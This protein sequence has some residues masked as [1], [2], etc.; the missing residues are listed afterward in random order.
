[1]AKFYFDIET[2]G[3]NIA[4]SPFT[5][6]IITVQYQP[7]DDATG[8]AKGDLVI[9][10]EW[11]SNEAEILKKIW[12][13]LKKWEFIMV[14]NNLS[15]ER[16]FL[17]EKARQYGWFNLNEYQLNYEFPAIDLQS[18]FVIL[19]KGQFRGCGMHNF[20]EK[21]MDG[22]KIK[23]WYENSQYAEI[24]N[25]VKDEAAGFI[26]FYSELCKK[27]PEIFPRKAGEQ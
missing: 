23:G 13:M 24:E 16:R 9:L 27:L 26:K 17:I 19:N 15:Y 18:I 14:G 3:P 4:P 20:T 25:Y 22:S 10:K 5:D 2:Y 8:E 1:M 6:K 11:E 7:L 12:P 21:K